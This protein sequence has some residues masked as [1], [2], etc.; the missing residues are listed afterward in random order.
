VTLWS[1]PLAFQCSHGFGE[2]LCL[3][4]AGRDGMWLTVTG[5]PVTRVGSN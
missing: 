3:K 4:G 1:G 5:G 2:F